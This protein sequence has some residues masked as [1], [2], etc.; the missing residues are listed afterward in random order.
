MKIL[1][2]RVLI[3]V[4]CVLAAQSAGLIGS[5]FTFPA[6]GSWYSGLNKPFF[7]PPNWIFGP[8]WTILYTLVGISLFY[9]YLS[10]NKLRKI[11]LRLFI[12]HLLLNSL[13]SIIFFGLKNTGLAFIE[14]VILWLT[15]IYLMKLF[16]RFEKRAFYLF[17]PYLIWITFASFLN[18]SIAILN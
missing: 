1:K 16:N 17:I 18:L 15:L 11:T 13:W 7:N 12:V 9:I 14:I 8:V 10:K 6:I 5:Y 4:L 3:L 2:N